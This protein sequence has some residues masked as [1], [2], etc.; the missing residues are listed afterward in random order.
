MAGVKREAR[1]CVSV[2]FHHVSEHDKNQIVDELETLIK[3]YN[4]GGWV[5]VSLDKSETP[6]RRLRQCRIGYEGEKA[7]S[8]SDSVDN[9]FEINVPQIEEQGEKVSHVTFLMDGV[10]VGSVYFPKE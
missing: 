8:I 2:E 6:P 1:W 7:E 5:K 10:E 4:G 3:Y 9:A